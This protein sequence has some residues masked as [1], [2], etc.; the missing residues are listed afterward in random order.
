M[1]RILVQSQFGLNSWG[2]KMARKNTLAHFPI[3]DVQS[4]GASFDTFS[5]P[6]NIDFLDNAGLQLT[7]TTAGTPIGVFEIY[8]S[9]DP[10]NTNPQA[11]V[12]IV[13]WT[14]LDFGNTIAINSSET[15]HIINMNQ[16]SFS[17]MAVK[18]VRSSGTGTIDG[19]L[20]VKMTGG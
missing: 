2:C 11:N 13:N 6:T 3:L 18:Y 4:L 16:L 7:W 8:V 5:T 20:T 12:P 15:S 17:W 1:R 9:N 14:Q 19:L 10:G